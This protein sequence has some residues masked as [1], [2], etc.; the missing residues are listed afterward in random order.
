MKV[1]I[2]YVYIGDDQENKF[3]NYFSSSINC[4]LIL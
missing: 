3:I 4:K 1:Y 2:I